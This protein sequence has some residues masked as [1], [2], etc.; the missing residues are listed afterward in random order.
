M[1]EIFDYLTDVCAVAEG[2]KA[3]ITVHKPNS[4]LLCPC[5][6]DKLNNAPILYNTFVN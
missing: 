5:S 1:K 4:Y 2:K 6:G 3:N